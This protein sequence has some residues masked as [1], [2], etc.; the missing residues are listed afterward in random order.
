MRVQFEVLEPVYKP[1][2]RHNPA[3]R[4]GTKCS[5]I[6]YKLRSFTNFYLVLHLP[7]G[8]VNRLLG[9]RHQPKLINIAP[10]ADPENASHW[11]CCD[12]DF[13]PSRLQI[14]RSHEIHD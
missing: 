5:F 9:Y 8:F 7:E 14:L 13:H 6:Q 10:M 11:L 3:L 12:D 1:L 2:M 4:I